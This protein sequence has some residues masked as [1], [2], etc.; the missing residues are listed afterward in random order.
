MCIALDAVSRKEV[1]HL[2]AWFAETMCGIACD[3][4]YDAS[5]LFHFTRRSGRFGERASLL[6]EVSRD[7]RE[8]QRVQYA[9]RWYAAL[10]RHLDTPVHVV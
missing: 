4:L 7:V 5:E 8:R 9:I 1:D 10:P 2:A 6:T 3:C